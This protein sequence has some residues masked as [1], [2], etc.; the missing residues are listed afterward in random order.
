LQATYSLLSAQLAGTSP[1]WRCL[2]EL[3]RTL[4]PSDDGGGVPSREKR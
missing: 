3:S 1:A 2:D 4:D